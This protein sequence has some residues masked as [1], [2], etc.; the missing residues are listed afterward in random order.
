MMGNIENNMYTHIDNMYKIHTLIC[1]YIHSR[2]SNRYNCVVTYTYMNIII[3]AE[4]WKCKL[5]YRTK[6]TRTCNARTRKTNR[7]QNSNSTIITRDQ[8]QYVCYM[9]CVHIVYCL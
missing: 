6:D 4:K 1:A 8:D 7:K 5:W 2:T 9:K 3:K